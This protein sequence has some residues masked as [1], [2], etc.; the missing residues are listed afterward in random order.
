MFEARGTAE[1]VSNVESLELAAV[2]QL[3]RSLLPAWNN[4]QVQWENDSSQQ[5][6]TESVPNGFI[7]NITLEIMKDPVVTTW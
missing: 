2:T 1:F 6:H 5:E 7:C 4:I 3:E